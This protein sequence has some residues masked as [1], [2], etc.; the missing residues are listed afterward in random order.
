MRDPIKNYHKINVAS[1]SELKKL[2]VVFGVSADTI[3]VGQPEFYKGLNNL[4]NN[5]SIEILKNY[6]CFHVMNDDADYLSHDFVDAKFA[7]NKLLTGQTQMKE[8]WKRM[9]TMVDRQLGDNLG[10]IYVQKYFTAADKERIN[11]L[12]DN[13]VS[14]YA[15]R[16]Q[17]LDWMSDSTKQKAIIK[18]HAIV[19][20]VGYP[21]KWKDYSS[22][23]ISKR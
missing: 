19:K 2:I 5:T 1:S 13:I 14:T 10:Q 12:I 23:D 4:M 11:Q 7:F 8:R 16:I 17:K 6:L 21:D 9:T 15:E 20:K 22:I 3:L 18:L